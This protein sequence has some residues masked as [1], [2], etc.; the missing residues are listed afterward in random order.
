MNI[1]QM[2]ISAA[3][4][5]L[6]I[7]AVRSLTFYTLPKKT[8]LVLWGVALF[9]L[10]VPFYIP[11]P[12]GIYTL[13]DRATETAAVTEAAAAET[14][15][16]TA[17]WQSLG[18]VGVSIPETA[19]IAPQI[20]PVVVIWIVGMVALSLFFISSHLRRRRVYKQALPV[21]NGY[22]AAWLQRN[23]LTR[24]VQIRQ[25]DRINTPMTYGVFRPVILLPKTTEWQDTEGLRYVLTHE[26]TH[27]KRLDIV[28]KWLLTAVLCVHW[29]NP[30]VWV[31][32]ILANR[33]IEFACDE[34]VVL[35]FGE[36]EKSAY[37]LTL[38]RLEEIRSGFSPL[39]INFAKNA[40][41]ER[42][43]AIMKLK[44]P[45]ALSITLAFVLVLT[46]TVG[47]FVANAHNGQYDSTPAAGYAA[48]GCAESPT[49]AIC[50][51]PSGMTAGTRVRDSLYYPPY[52]TENGEFIN[53]TESY[54]YANETHDASGPRPY[55]SRAQL[56]E[57]AF[58]GVLKQ[59]SVYVRQPHIQPE[60][61]DW[62]GDIICFSNGP[63]GM[64]NN[65]FYFPITGM[66]VCS[67]C[68][69]IFT[70]EQNMA[71]GW[72]CNG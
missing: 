10:I 19:E 26:Q 24:P 39:T 30:L 8:F 13:S 54:A 16:P 45:S 2:S 36:T 44:K 61:I 32:Y 59:S 35:T 28:T 15:S 40:I 34:T 25:S 22:A 6:V 1:L 11:V 27:I 57:I 62:S 48:Y 70:E 7:A 9:R 14:A 4:L 21:E 41:T 63:L 58:A 33:D 67:T 53:V 68:G 65:S 52:Y 46:V 23:K 17:V 66:R 47:A 60:Q 31:M 20:S 55:F 72:Y 18:H 3:V 49:P 5:I 50:L 38:V 51:I 29:F 43:T 12:L 37:A 71:I 42:I 56:Q 69:Y 64:C